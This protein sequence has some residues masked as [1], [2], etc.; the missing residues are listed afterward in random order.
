LYGDENATKLSIESGKQIPIKNGSTIT[1]YPDDDDTIDFQM[2]LAKLQDDPMWSSHAFTGAAKN[3]NG[4]CVLALDEESSCLKPT[5][6]R[7]KSELSSTCC[8]IR[9]AFVMAFADGYHKNVRGDRN[10]IG[11]G[12]EENC[13]NAVNSTRSNSK[14][15]GLL[16]KVRATQSTES[17]N[18]HESVLEHCRE[19]LQLVFAKST[20][21]D[22]FMKD[23]D[24]SF[25]ATSF[26]SSKHLD[27]PTVTFAMRHRCLRVASILVPQE[28]LEQVL[29]RY[30]F[31]TSFNQISLKSCTFGAFCA[32]EL[33]E[34]HLP[35]P[36][37]D[38]GQLSQM[39][40]P[41]YARALWRHHRDIKGSKGRLLLLIVELYLREPISDYVFFNTLLSEIGSLR[42]PRTL[43]L[44]LESISRYVNKLG[45]ESALNFFKM[46][47]SSVLPLLA[48]LTSCI[49]SALKCS[50]ALSSSSNEDNERAE[51]D[52]GS[53]T[54]TAFRLAQ[55]MVCFS[56]DPDSQGTLIGY[57]NDL[58]DLVHGG[59]HEDH[60]K[61]FT[62]ILHQLVPRI[63]TEDT[64]KELTDR[65]MYS[66]N[67]ST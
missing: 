63:E 23:L 30:R 11:E 34:M 67:L 5:S 27:T 13:L 60:Q 21:A 37:S 47:S 25:A 14:W 4:K 51:N 41:S 2:D 32:K 65:F 29:R 20:S 26:N 16:S 36:H 53:A 15:K 44:A 40:F 61:T 50:F 10:S 46:V 1:G 49:S 57:C 66:R 59:A 9:I 31:Q 42:L 6:S 56:N 28:A 62:E 17:K 33:E 8:A 18:Q 38:L 64:R 54:D 52:L 35:I 19:L 55:V 48:S 22:F 58:I 39:H 12:N 7:E 45:L 43:L 3:E 24:V